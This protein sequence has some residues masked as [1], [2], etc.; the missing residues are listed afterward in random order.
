MKSGKQLYDVF[1][2]HSLTDRQ[3]AAEVADVLRSY[4]LSV[5]VDSTDLPPGTNIE[6][7]VWEAIAESRAVVVTISASP[8]GAS[9]LVELGAAKAWN[10]PIYGVTSQ[11]ALPHLPAVFHEMKVYPSSRMDEIARSIVQSGEPLSV[12]D[13][14]LLNDLYVQVGVPVDQLALQPLHLTELVKLFNKQGERQ[15]SGEQVM[16]LLLRSRKQGLLPS[17]TKRPPKKA[18]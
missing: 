3:L 17:L 9:M 11:A 1:V 13:S 18:S 5:F 8:P 6:E 7:T 4:E 14:K 12:H 2:A 15:L 16:T 10:K